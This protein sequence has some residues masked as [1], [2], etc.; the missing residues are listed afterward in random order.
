MKYPIYTTFRGKT[1][2]PLD[3][4]RYD[5]CW[6]AKTSDAISIGMSV[7][8]A[9]PGEIY[10]IEICGYY[11]FNFDRWKSFGWTICDARFYTID[12]GEKK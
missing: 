8:R 12:F 4:L 10:D 9:L 3:M 1:P 5:Q 11:P 2:F 7:S 6:P